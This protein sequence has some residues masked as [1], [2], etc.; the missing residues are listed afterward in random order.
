[1]TLIPGK[2]Y[3]I[4]YWDDTG[5]ILVGMYLK[6]IEGIVK[7][8]TRGRTYDVMYFHHKFLILNKVVTFSTA[9]WERMYKFKI[10]K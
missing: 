6:T 1:M 3:E 7:H 5:P 8:R 10:V 9:K 2:L 4:H